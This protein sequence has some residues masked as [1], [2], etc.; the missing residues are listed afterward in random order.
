MN[1]RY[2]RMAQ[3]VDVQHVARVPPFCSK[4]H[5]NK[6]RPL[7]ALVLQALAKGFLVVCKLPFPLVEVKGAPPFLDFD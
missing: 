6:G 2:L 4:S 1:A 3:A 5:A 7:Q